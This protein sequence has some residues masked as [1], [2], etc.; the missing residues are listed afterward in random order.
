MHFRPF[1]HI[2]SVMA[3]LLSKLLNTFD[4]VYINES[5]HSEMLAVG[6]AVGVACVFSAPVGGKPCLIDS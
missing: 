4:S 2:G 5:R 3:N 6:C 1:V